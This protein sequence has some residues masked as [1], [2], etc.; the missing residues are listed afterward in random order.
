MRLRDNKVVAILDHGDPMVYGNWLWCLNAFKELAIKVEPG[1][2]LFHAANAALRDDISFSDIAKSTII[3]TNDTP[4][5]RDT[6]DKLASNSATMVVFCQK[7]KFTSVLIKL[8]KKYSSDTPIA[9]I[10][11][12]GYAEKELVIWGTIANIEKTI[13][14]QKLPQEFIIFVGANLD[15]PKADHAAKAKKK[16]GKLYLMGLYPGNVDLVTLRALNI[17][18]QS[19][20]IIDQFDVLEKGYEHKHILHGKEIWGPSDKEAWIWHGHGKSAKDFSG[21]NLERFVAAEKARQETIIKV[22]KAIE[23]GKQVCILEWGDPLTYAPWSWILREFAD[24]APIAVP[25]ISSF[26]AANAALQKSVTQGADT[27]SVILTVPDVDDWLNKTCFDF[28]EMLKRAN[29]LW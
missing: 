8:S 6:I 24:L 16:N 2:C 22:R 11:N 3:T 14:K 25:A 1:V 29:F 18:K 21:K 12:A 15:R 19:D 23:K 13:T 7:N 20:L 10:I 26:D 27:K 9:L 17:I 28:D 5:Q 4:E